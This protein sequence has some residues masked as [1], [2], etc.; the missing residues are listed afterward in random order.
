MGKKSKT[1]VEQAPL[2]PFLQNQLQETYGLAR[3]INPA[4]FAGE[5]V[6]GFTP[7]EQQAQLMT[8]QRA[9]AGDPTVQRAQG[10]LGNV[11]GGS[12]RPTY[13][14]GFLGDIAAGRSQTNPFLQAQI[15][16]A[17]SGAVNQATSQYALGGRLGSGAFGTAL[18]AGITGAAAPILAQ[19]VE[20][21]RA[22][23]MQAAG[24]LISAEQQNRARQMQAAGMAPELAQ[25]RFRDLSILQ[26]IGADQRQMQQAQIQAQQDFINEL[27]AAQQARLQARV[28]ATGLTP[29][30]TGQTQT[31]SP[32][33]LDTLSQLGTTATL[34]Y[35]ALSDERMKEN[36]E[37]I[38][39]PIMKVNMLDGVTFNYKD[40]PGRVAGLM[41]QDVERVLPMA[42]AEQ[43]NG[44]KAVN[45]AQ[46]TGLLTEAVKEL[47][48]KVARLEAGRS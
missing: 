15:D 42:V 25:E 39:D 7:L 13:A 14:E 36:V 6:A 2:P 17:I 11:I 40:Q 3:S 34:A 9:A 8:A 16:N 27:N 22:R 31:S 19:Q 44:M 12:A 37:Q 45:Y 26:G 24:Q 4:V 10:L 1:T 33:T 5:R 46:V 41:A 30:Q 35:M 28:A 29:T 32:S 18:G 48:N 23:Q 38:E 20:A 43:D 21:D 47:S